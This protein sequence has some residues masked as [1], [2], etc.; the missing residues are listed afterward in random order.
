MAKLDLT[1][2]DDTSLDTRLAETRQELF[3]LRF[4]RATGQLEDH[5]AIRK[6][7]RE[8]ARILTELRQR[9]IAEAESRQGSRR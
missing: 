6:A 2:L 3:N 4:R 1:E 5:R 7:R 8:V 9:E